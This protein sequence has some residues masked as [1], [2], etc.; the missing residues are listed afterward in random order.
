MTSGYFFVW[1]VV[2]FFSGVKFPPVNFGPKE[3]TNIYTGN[4]GSVFSCNKIDQKKKKQMNIWFPLNASGFSQ[5]LCIQLK[6]VYGLFC[7]VF[8]TSL[9]SI[10][11]C[12]YQKFPFPIHFP[13]SLTVAIQ[14]TDT[15]TIT[16]TR[17]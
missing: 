7:F 4:K 3:K 16:T 17:K 1:F 15:T 14:V 13:F 2:V 6:Y 8:F 12:S 11:Y 5:S 9:L 10:I